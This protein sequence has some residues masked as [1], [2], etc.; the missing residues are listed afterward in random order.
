MGKTL[1]ALALAGAVLGAA[2]TEV[3]T[4]APDQPLFA[5]SK[6]ATCN[7]A[8]PL[9]ITFA[10]GA[11]DALKS[12]GAGAYMD[13]V[14]N[15]GAHING[16]TGNLMLWPSQNGS[17]SRYVN[18]IT[19]VAPFA[20]KDRIY[21]NNHN[22]T[23]GLA[24]IPNGGAGTAVLEAE[25]DIGGTDFGIVRYGK[26]CAGTVTGPKVNIGRS[27]DGSTWTISG[28]SGLYCARNGKKPGSYVQAGTVGGFTMTL[29][30][31]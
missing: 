23:C 28:T 26:N 24:G 17:T 7:A 12:D 9:S 29:Q 31:P 6:P 10:D 11:S 16:P 8:T 1:N 21:T 19:S 27:A 20:T 13:G 2:C 15:V 18:V 14:D 22:T 30:G 3:P 25:L 5:R 4:S